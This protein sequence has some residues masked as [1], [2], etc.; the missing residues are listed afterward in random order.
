MDIGI[1][2]SALEVNGELGIDTIETG[3]ETET[4][5]EEHVR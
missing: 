4:E 2:G 3:R 1:G 5:T